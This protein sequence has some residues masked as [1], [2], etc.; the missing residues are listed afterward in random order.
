MV[1]AILVSISVF[2]ALGIIS[3]IGAYYTAK[4]NR[5]DV[6]IGVYVLF[7]TLA[8]FFAAKIAEFDFGIIMWIAPVG[9]IVFPF[10]LQVTDMVNEKFGR[11]EVYKMIMIAFASQVIMVFFLISMFRGPRKKQQE[12]KK[13]I[14]SLQKNDR[15]RTIGG[16]HGTVVDVRDDEIVLKVD[17]SNNTKIRISPSAIGTKLSEKES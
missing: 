5:S 13:M 2:V 4:M 15:I 8:Q 12:H 17:E 3:Y 10:T 6:L 11:K 9:V 7:I 14:Q 1:S 16:I